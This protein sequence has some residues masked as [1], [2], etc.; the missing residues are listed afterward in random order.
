[1]EKYLVDFD[2]V[3]L[4][5]QAKFD[6]VMMGN[7]NFHDWNK[8]LNSINWREFYESCNEIDDAFNSLY[9]LQIN[10]RL[11]AIITAIHSFEEGHEKTLILRKNKITVPII[12]V[13]PNQ[14]KSIIYPPCKEDVLIDD[15]EKNCI[16]FEKAGGKALLFRPKGYYGSK[17]TVKSLKE[18]L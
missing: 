8:Y 11:K 6:E 9:K 14:E 13:L 12:F 7:T 1:M 17:K 3:V 15:K 2:G 10:N 4:D 16:N 5:S 18:L